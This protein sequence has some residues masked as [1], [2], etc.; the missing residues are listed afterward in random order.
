[1]AY[2]AANWPAPKNVTALSTL[3]SG[4]VSSGDFASFNLAT[5]V[6]DLETNVVRNRAQLTSEKLPNPAV[7]LNQT[8]STDVVVIDCPQQAQQVANA[9]GLYTKLVN[10][11]LAIMT[12]DCLPVFLCD[13]NGQEIAALHAGW[14]GLC[15]GIIDN[16]MTL[17]EAPPSDIFAYLGPAISQS[18]FE[19]G[20]EVRDAFCDWFSLSEAYFK[21]Q[22]NA[23]YLADLYGIAKARLN[24]FGVTHVFGGEHCTYRQSTLFYSYRRQGQ[25]GRNAHIIWRS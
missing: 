1:M 8:H 14:R 25:C 24:T 4:G 15:G 2:L 19:V 5:H 6:N 18:N 17:F 11:P 22:N 21:P 9:D 20:K 10:T 3:R 23:K 16:A 12:A 13:A 7:W